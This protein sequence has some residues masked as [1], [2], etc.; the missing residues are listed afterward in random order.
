MP[1]TLYR[2]VI[3]SAALAAALAALVIG[4]PKASAAGAT[5]YVAPSGTD[6]SCATNSQTSPFATI[7]AALVCADDGDAI[8]LAP[9][10]ATPYPGVG[11]ISHSISITAQAGESARSVRI[12]VSEPDMFTGGLDVDAE[13]SVAVR[14]VSLDCVSHNCVAPIVANHGTLD[15]HGTAVTGAGNTQAVVNLSTGSTPARLT[16]AGSLIAHN[17]NAGMNSY[18]GAGIFTGV[19]ATTDAPSVLTV[20]NSTITDNTN[21]GGVNAGAGIATNT[22]SVIRLVNSTITDNHVP[23]IGGRGAG[24]YDPYSAMSQV[25]APIT[26]SN[27]VIAGN[28]GGNGPDCSGKISDGTGGHNLIGVGSGCVG[29]IDGVNGDIVG[30]ADAGLGALANHGGPTDTVA[31][32]PPS[33]AI[34]HGDSN[35]CTSLADV[36]QRGYA[37]T[38]AQDGCDIGAYESGAVAAVAPDHAAPAV[39]IEAP[40]SG[41]VYTQDQSAAAAFECTDEASGSGVAACV[42]DVDD[43][44]PLDT[45]T[46]GSHSFT[47]T[48]KDNASNERVRTVD[49]TVVAKPVLPTPRAKSADLSLTLSGFATR[50]EEGD[51]VEGVLIATNVGPDESSATVELRIVGGRPLRA[52]GCHRQGPTYACSLPSVKSGAQA[53]LPLAI[54][55]TRPGHLRIRARIIGALPDPSAANNAARVA[56]KVKTGK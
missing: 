44:A 19:Q 42:G 15:L 11:E 5:Y 10:G 14:G 36:D 27:T 2:I 39:S 50:A 13:T 23:G 45:A 47:V 21:E 28:T 41:A 38:S 43:G 29:P 16:I 17:R 26:A 12:D 46:T 20:S 55:A 25:P 37:R 30:V 8:S 54:K 48:G 24:V 51:L 3:A 32:Q 35:V 49:Y 1:T 34:E 6:A 53:K 22:S 7:Q 33:P 40:L 31:L 56:V 52:D 4:V 18:P 9:T